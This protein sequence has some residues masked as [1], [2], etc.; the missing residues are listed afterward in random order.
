MDFFWPKYSFLEER[1]KDFKDIRF[2][3]I[4]YADWLLIKN[5]QLKPNEKILDLPWNNS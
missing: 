5:K 1:H 2:R 3:E 4:S